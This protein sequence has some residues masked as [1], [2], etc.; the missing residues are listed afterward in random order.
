[1]R[2]LLARAADVPDFAT[3]AAYL[4]EMQEKVRRCF[5]RIVG[6]TPPD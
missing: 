1:L 6:G 2:E 5:E 4:A 3:L